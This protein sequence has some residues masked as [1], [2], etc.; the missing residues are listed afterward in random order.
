M[1]AYTSDT[2][3][4]N[5]DS[6][7]VP[8]HTEIEVPACLRVSFQMHS[9]LIEYMT[10]WLFPIFISDSAYTKSQGLLTEVSPSLLFNNIIKSCTVIGRKWTVRSF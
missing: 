9:H 8:M 10:L 3:S 5:A 4:P 2:K 6:D 7:Q 1:H